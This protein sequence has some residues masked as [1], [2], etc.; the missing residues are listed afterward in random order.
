MAYEWLRYCN[1]KNLKERG[2]YGVRVARPGFDANNC[3]DNQL[4]FNSGWP[5]LQLVQMLDFDIEYTMEYRYLLPNGDWSTTLP[6]GYTLDDTEPWEKSGKRKYSVNTV[7]A[8]MGQEVRWY[9]KSSNIVR[10]DVYR[11]K[12][13]N[14]GYLPVFLDSDDVSGKTTNKLL[15]FNVDLGVDVDYPYTEAALPM[16]SV[17]NDYGMKSSSIFGDRVPGL[18][19]GQ[20]SKLV[21]AV[22]TEQTAKYNLSN[23]SGEGMVPIWSP[24]TSTPSTAADSSILMPYE[25]WGYGVEGEPVYDGNGNFKKYVYDEGADGGGYYYSVCP[26]T[27][28]SDMFSTSGSFNVNNNSNGYVYS[29]IGNAV[30]GQAFKKASL[31]ILRSPLVSPRYDIIE[32]PIYE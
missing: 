1:T 3:A 22:K 30:S 20:F 24:L 31:V 23:L 10:C 11:R 17:P 25:A 21:Q 15:L 9:H 5:I 14:L 12:V 28:L 4:I 7:Y 27:P 19:T 2:N 29:M 32:G 16:V 18:S 13:H 6:S 8:R 26:A